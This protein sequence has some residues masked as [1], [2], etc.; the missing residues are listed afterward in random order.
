MF[1][2]SLLLAFVFLT[3]CQIAPTSQ[4]HA[5]ADIEKVVEA[6]RASILEKDKPKYMSLFFSQKP[7]E[8]GWQHVSED[9]RLARIR[10]TKPDA[11]KARRLPTNTFENLIDSAVAASER[12]EE[13]FSNLQI[14]TDGDI[15]SVYFDYEFWEGAKKTNWGREHW[16]LLRTEAGWKIF[17]VIYSIHDE[18]SI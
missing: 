13:R 17:S 3:G 16:Q 1:C 4:T 10:Q 11:I 15:A 7:S 2:R 9:V 6:F 18:L 12:W 5:V 8:I 14:T